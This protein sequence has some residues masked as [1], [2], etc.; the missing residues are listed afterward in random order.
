LARLSDGGAWVYQEVRAG[1]SAAEVRGAYFD[2]HVDMEKQ[3][4]CLSDSLDA[5]LECFNTKSIFQVA[6]F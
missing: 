4:L 5:K 1:L 3:V 2:Q 6:D